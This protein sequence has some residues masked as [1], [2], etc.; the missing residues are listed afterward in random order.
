MELEV[1][2]SRRLARAAAVERERLSV[3]DALSSAWKALEEMSPPTFQGD[4]PA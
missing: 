3:D 1:L 4:R 2:E